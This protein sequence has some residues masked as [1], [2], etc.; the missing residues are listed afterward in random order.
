[1]GIIL[2]FMVAAALFF[3][4]VATVGAG[5]LIWLFV[6]LVRH[7]DPAWSW[8]GAALLILYGGVLLWWYWR[9][10]DRMSMSPRGCANCG[11]RWKRR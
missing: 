4:F 8:P 2:L 5:G 3:C 9:Q 11:C 10:N 1:M 6:Y 7:H